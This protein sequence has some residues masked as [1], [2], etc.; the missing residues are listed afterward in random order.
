MPPPDAPRLTDREA[1]RRFEAAP[2]VGA[3]LTRYP[4]D[5]P[6]RRGDVRREDG[7]LDGEDLV[8]R[9]R[10]DRRG[11]RRRRHRLGARGV[12]GAAGRLEDGP[13][14]LGGVRRLDDQQPVA[15]GGSLPRLPP[16]SRRP[17]PAAL[18]PE[19]RPA[20]RALADGVALVLQP[21]RRLHRRAALLSAA[22]VGRRA[23]R[24]ARRHGARR[25]RPAV[26]ADV[27]ARRGGRLPR[28]LPGRAQRR[29]LERD[30]R[31]LLG[32][33]RRGADRPRRG[34]LG[35]LPDRGRPPGVRPRGRLGRD[36]RPHPDERALRVGEPAGR[37]VRPRRLRGVHPRLPQP[38]AGRGSGTT[39]RPR[40]SRRSR[41]TC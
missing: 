2:K 33:D 28:R 24:L 21:R 17:A 23:R 11:P 1:L 7:E 40:T 5:G 29:V 26:L 25:R 30:R 27:G 22:R 35:Q 20:V 10:R 12:D 14:L 13:R 9:G 37:H 19:P 8:G 18:A 39:C 41:S 3:W 15:L 6:L 32:G 16:R 38:S 4:S 31:R 34:A 36:P